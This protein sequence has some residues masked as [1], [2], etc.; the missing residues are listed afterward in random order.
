MPLEIACFN[1]TSALLASFSGA[2]RIELCADPSVGGIT[3]SLVDF[4]FVKQS[5]QRSYAERESDGR[6]IP[7]NVM[8]RP[9]GGG[10]VY[11]DAEFASME[12]EME[13]FDENG[14]D[15]F[16]FGILT[17]DS[18][19][20]INIKRCQILLSKARGKPCTFHRAFDALPPSSMLA[21][22]EILVELGF[23]SVLTSGGAPSAIG[24][25]EVLRDLVERALELNREQRDIEVIIGGGVRSGNLGGMRKEIYAERDGKRGWWHSSA[26]TDAQGG[27][28]ASKE[29]ILALAELLRV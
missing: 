1:T 27:E 4:L 20:Q 12:R 23:T 21:Q 24:G 11:S 13:I 8:I 25:K 15:G 7:I 6:D 17:P 19:P 14:A 26:V 9:R 16:V 28:V 18:E 5:L 3:P 22:L 2:D 29:E 10:F